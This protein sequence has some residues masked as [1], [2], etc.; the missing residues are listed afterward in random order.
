MDNETAALPP[1]DLNNLDY[2]GLMAALVD[3]YMAAEDLDE[4]ALRG[5]LGI[6]TDKD[7][8]PEI[9]GATPQ[10]LVKGR[11]G[12]A[13]ILFVSRVID[14]IDDV[15]GDGKM[16]WRQA[17]KKKLFGFYTVKGEITETI[18]IETPG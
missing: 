15:H 10:A 16:E 13:A 2:Q 9:K 17:F 3:A 18:A 11:A 6:N 4:I 12:V 1:L 14:S 7:P 5:L 8:E